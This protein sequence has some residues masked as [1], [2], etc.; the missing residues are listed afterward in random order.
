MLDISV[1]IVNYNT[2]TLTCQ[3][4][5]S[6]IQKTQNVSYEIIL[7]DNASAECD[8]DLFKQKFPEITLIKSAENG[9]FAK[10]NNLGIAQAKGEYIL[11]L[12]SDTELINNAL[13]ETVMVM[14]ANPKAG[15]MSGKLLYPDGRVQ[16]V[17]GRLPSLKM[18]FEELLRLNKSLTPAQ[19]AIY[20]LGNEFDYETTLNV[21]WVW[22]AFFVFPA[23]ILQQFPQH[24][25]QDD[26]FMYGEDLQ[27]CWYI[28]DL[29]Y[30]IM[31]SPKPVAYHYISASS[32]INEEEKALK[33]SLPNLVLLMRK[34]KG[35][36]YTSFYFLIKALHLL[37]LRNKKD[38]QKAIATLKIAFS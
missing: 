5:E 23:K 26:F 1:V 29:G 27:W 36:F 33:K 14:R 8:A 2:F 25:L 24:K 4:I 37:S 28:K 18:E 21:G 6:V 11:L 34:Q 10:G 19:R 15:V 16:G 22:G 38:L 32:K 3:C 9:G 7:V 31:Y 20:Y 13:Y 12:N 17:A 30:D 35:Y